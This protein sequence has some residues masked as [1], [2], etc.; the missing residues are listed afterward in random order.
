MEPHGLA[1]LDYIHGST[2]ETINLERD[3]GYSEEMPINIYF[4]KPSD[5]YPHEHTALDLCFG[6]ILDIGAGTGIHSLVLQERGFKVTAIDISPEAVKVMEHLGVKDAQCINIYD[7]NSGLFDTLLLLG[8][9]IG[10]TGDLIGLNR[11]LNH[12]KKILNPGGQL[13]L[14][15]FDVRKTKIPEH[16]K[17]HESNLKA[18]K[19]IGEIRFR[20]IYKEHV[21]DYFNW[22]HLDY[23]T[24]SGHAKKSG[25]ISDIIAE[26]DDGHYLAKLSLTNLK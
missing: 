14:N 8:R 9:G 4:R 21:G 6:K 24:L 7:F 19:Y 25:W 23:Q 18:N 3:D 1:L 17:Y 22:L 11:F 15:S 16:I 26:E 2:S 13:L 12:C 20:L 10:L 5:F